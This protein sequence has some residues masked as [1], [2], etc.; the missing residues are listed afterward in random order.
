MCIIQ[1]TL[2]C[3]PVSAVRIHLNRNFSDIPTLSERYILLTQNVIFLLRRSDIIFANNCPKGNITRLQPNITAQLFHSFRKER[4]S[5]KKAPLS[6]CFFLVGAGGFTL[7]V[8]F[9]RYANR[10]ILCPSRLRQG[11]PTRDGQ[12]G[13]NPP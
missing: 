3:S 5:L 9:V 7:R 2:L 13:S 10:R 6:R 8:K 1:R 4:I 12:C 11:E